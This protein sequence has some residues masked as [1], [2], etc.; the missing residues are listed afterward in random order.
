MSLIV[1]TFQA[2]KFLPVQVTSDGIELVETELQL[3]KSNDSIFV[4][5]GTDK[6]STPERV[7]TL[8]DKY[9]PGILESAIDEGCE[10]IQFSF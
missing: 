9:F 10:F 5:I 2:A 6:E 3:I 1:D 7:T 8:L 4:E